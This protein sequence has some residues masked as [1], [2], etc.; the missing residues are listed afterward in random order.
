ML[1]LRQ[2]SGLGAG[3]TP[4]AHP[5][6]GP[7]PA[8]PDGSVPALPAGIEA[9]IFDFDGTLADTT[10]HHEQALRATLRRHGVALDHDWYREH[11]GLSIHD[12]MAALPDGQHL[13]HNEIIAQSRAHLLA[14]M[15]HIAPIECAVSLLR[16]ARRAGLRC[17]VASGASR[18]LLDPGIDVLGLRLQFAAVVAREDVTHGKPAPDLYLTAARTLGIPPDRCLA[19]DDAP[20]GIAAARAAG[21][22]V[23][24][25]VDG[26]LAPATEIAWR[27]PAR[28]RA[29]RITAFPS[30]AGT[31]QPHWLPPDA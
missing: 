23:I 31:P 6:F 1:V 8:P 2:G 26:R 4:A 3:M 19:V 20:D 12:L 17:A 14:T 21:M 10:A 7:D 24:T 5:S 25:L 27:R 18:L 11:V 29:D 16:T 9:V 15:H 22:E 30:P 28:Q 13:P